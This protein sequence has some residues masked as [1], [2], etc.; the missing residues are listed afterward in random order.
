MNVNLKRRLIRF[1]TYILYQLSELS[2][3]CEG[4]NS[5]DLTYYFSKTTFSSSSEKY[6]NLFKNIHIRMLFR[7]QMCD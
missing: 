3:E 6:G 5:L 7:R 4:G 1:T 2:K